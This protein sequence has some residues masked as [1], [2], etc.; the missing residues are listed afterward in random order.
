MM[1]SQ[2]KAS[3]YGWDLENY[4]IFVLGVFAANHIPSYSVKY[5]NYK[6]FPPIYC[7]SK[8]EEKLRQ[9]FEFRFGCQFITFVN[10]QQFNKQ[11][12]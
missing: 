9:R 3:L 12:L 4:S 10:I 8:L 5:T 2:S 1:A 11:I 6:I 7:Y